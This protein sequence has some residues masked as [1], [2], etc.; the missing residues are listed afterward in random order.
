MAPPPFLPPPHGPKGR[1][2]GGE[3]SLPPWETNCV[4]PINFSHPLTNDRLTQL[5]AITGQRVER[6]IEIPTHL[7]PGRP[8]GPQIVELANSVGLTIQE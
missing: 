4:S 3:K 2:E 1:G 6:V 7:D 8:F 5:E